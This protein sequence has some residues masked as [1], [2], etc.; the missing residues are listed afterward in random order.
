MSP[1]A[2]PG[3]SGTC[4]LY[5]SDP[6]SRLGGADANRAR[7][8]KIEELAA[9]A[10]AFAQMDFTFLFDPSRKLMT[11]GFNV[12]ERRPDN[13]FYDLLASEARLGSFIA[14]AQGQVPQEHWFA[15][16]RLLVA[17]RGEPTL[18]SW[19]GSMFEYL[20]PLLVMPTYENTLLD[21][22]YKG[23]VERQIEYG[24]L[25]VYKRQSLPW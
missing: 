15:L 24:R 14:I 8:A 25:D 20:M 4:L 13:S 12:T 10:E 7:L 6:S 21:E 19:S 5:T 3:A 17:G 1:A 23:A 18:A 11:V 16:S 2:T 9:R 22:T